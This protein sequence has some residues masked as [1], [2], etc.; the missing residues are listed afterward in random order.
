MSKRDLD[1]HYPRTSACMF[2]RTRYARHRLIDVIRDRHNKAGESVA[3]L[4]KDYDL[5]RA[6]I[7][8]A[9]NS[10]PDDNRMTLREIRESDAAYRK[11]GL[12]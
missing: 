5:R 4:V 9:I 7:L 8:A 1:K 10:T 11:A 12:R 2:H 3:S 6:A